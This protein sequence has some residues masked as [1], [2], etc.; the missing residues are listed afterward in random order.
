MKQFI[1]KIALK[2][3]PIKKLKTERDALRDE[4]DTLLGEYKFVPPGHFYSAIPSLEEIRRREKQIWDVVPDKLPGIDLNTEKQ[5]ICFNEFAAYY[6]EMPFPDKKN[7]LRYYFENPSYSYSDAICLYSMIRK[8]KPLRIIEVGS[9]YSSCVMMDTNELFF[10]DKIHI[11]FI[12]PYVDLLLSL[13]KKD[14]RSRNTVIPSIV[15]DVELDI[16]GKLEENDIL[17]IDS[18][19]VSKIGSDVNHILFNI[20]PKLNKGV[21]IHFHDV[22][23]PFE[24]PKEWIYGGKAWNEAYVLRAFLQYNTSFEIVFYN[25]YLELF[26]ADKFK[27]YMPLCLK[28]PGG[29]IWLRKKGD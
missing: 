2:I 7:S 11:T 28:N 9:G 22:F 17:F 18:T 25:T 8:T 10:S 26:Y 13:M 20:L 1:K 4:R 27:R 15:Q 6:E 16:F 14:D 19:H 3:P 24:Y 29:S 5:L 23:Y 12:E 21:L